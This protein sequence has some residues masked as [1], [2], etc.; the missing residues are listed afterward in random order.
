V[1]ELYVGD[2]ADKPEKRGQQTVSPSGE[3]RKSVEFSL[4][5]LELGVHQGHVRITAGDALSCDDVRYF[6]VDV[7]P[8]TKVL[9]LAEN[10]ESTLF[11]R[12]ALSPSATVGLVQAKFAC[13]VE[14]YTGLE[15]RPLED[16][17]A[18]C[19]LDPPP[20]TSASWKTLVDF[21]DRGGGVGI[22]LGRNAQGNRDEMNS[23]EAQELLPAKLRWQSRDETYVRPVAV[24]HP[25]MGE[26]RD[27]AD[28]P[29]SEF[30]VF[31]YWDLEGGAAGSNVIASFAN[32]K[33]ALVERQIGGGRVLMMT[34]PISDP[35]HDDPWNLLPTGSEPWPFLAL[36]NGIAEYLAAAGDSRL[37]F[38]AGQAVLL[39]LSASEQVT[40]YVL[41]L[42]DGSALRQPLTP[43]QTDLSIASTEM[44]GNYRLRAGGQQGKLDRGFS[45]NVPAESSRLERASAAAIANTLGKE[46]TR[47]ARTR[48]EIEVR[49]GLARRGRELFPVL[50]LAL[51][52]VLAT[53]GLLANRFYRGADVQSKSSASRV[54]LDPEWGG[55]PPGS[56]PTN[57]G[58]GPPGSLSISQSTP[59]GAGASESQR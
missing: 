10:E 45:V 2:E 50:I 49:V 58:G 18:I 29:W 46:R 30:P 8:P 38:H 41:Q 52:L 1:V 31:K 43:G 48:D 32:G 51:A 25:A 27:L 54:V 24:E 42:P 28:V 12:E 22:F 59:V 4:S 39:P 9:L 37:N 13:D 14:T 6:T 11:L 40:N 5:G 26:L 17:A 56:P 3:Q 15:S 34:T 44:V 19:L 20:L 57:R 53:E 16:Y 7:R 21:A 23:A 36:A 35:A 55:E 33:P 47:V